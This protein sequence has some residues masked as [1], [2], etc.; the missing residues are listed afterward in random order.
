MEDVKEDLLPPTEISDIESVV[1][2]ARQTF[3]ETLPKDYLSTEEY[4]LYERLYGPP[5][6]ETR[7]DDLMF[8]PGSE[9]DLD[10]PEKVRNVL[11]KEME[12]GQYEEIE[13]DPSL[14]YSVVPQEEE[15]GVDNPEYEG[16]DIDM[17]TESLEIDAEDHPQSAME[18]LLENH[19]EESSA[20]IQAQNRREREA[21]SRLQKD[22]EVALAKQEEDDLAEQEA[23]EKAMANGE[24]YMEEPDVEEEEVDEEDEDHEGDPYYSSDSIRTHPH[25]MTGR[26]GT[27]PSTLSLPRARLTDPVKQL[28]TRSDIKHVAEAAEKAFGGPGLPFSSSTPGSKKML[29]QKEIGL[30]ASQHKMSEIEADAYIAGV[31]PGTYA[32]AM[33]TLVEVRKRLGTKWIRDF[34]SKNNGEGPAVLDAGA[35]GAGIIAWQEIMEAEWDIMRDEGLAEG[36]YQS[37][38]KSTVLTGSNTLRHRVSRFLE[39]TTFLP[40]LPD[41]LHSSRGRRAIDGAEPQE[42][43]M[44]DIIIAP[45][46]LFPLKEDW[47]RKNMVSNLWGLLNPNGGVLILIEKGLPRGFEA[48]A[49][50][51]SLLLDTHISSPGKTTYENELDS[52]AS[53]EGRFVEKEEGMII[54][55]CTNH[56]AC[57]MYPI[58]GLSSGRK[59]FCHFRQR[60]I[61]PEYLQRLL[62]ARVRNHEDVKFSYIAVRRGKDARKGAKPLVQGVQATL[63]SF[64]G[65]ED[66]DLPTSEFGTSD[67]TRHKFHTLG[68]PRAILPPLKRRGHVT[69]DLCTPSGKLERWTVPKSF[70]RT[71]Y[72]DARKSQWGDLWALGAKTRV[73]RSPRLGRLSHDETGKEIKGVRAERA[74]TKNKNKKEQYDMIV[75]ENGLEGIKPKREKYARRTERRTKG[76]RIVKE[77]K[78][79]TE[80]DI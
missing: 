50:A 39:N 57:P 10:G 51:R 73:A 47:R 33:S 76:G 9:E 34:F 16:Q 31:M 6:R 21:I 43:K 36:P 52:T 59:D 13:F 5:T 42:R 71:A 7:P 63:Q 69:L 26:G 48:I 62:G 23:H 58:P 20:H 32:A 78:I 67:P 53:E 19:V 49:G 17:V 2:Q 64:E 12:D 44:Y 66:Y 60:F 72:R 40:R 25:T 46:T 68:L 24:S 35:A 54:A 28:L 75:G 29:P 1:R 27:I 74:K 65:Y 80:D 55:P 77:Q 45:H 11:L 18:E 38:G 8:I 22:F 79:I 3:G 4:M 14:G 41:Y 30:D 37:F 56:T 61:R 70:S 15:G